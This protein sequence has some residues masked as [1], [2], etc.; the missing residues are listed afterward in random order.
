MGDFF[1]VFYTLMG[2]T[3]LCLTLTDYVDSITPRMTQICGYILLCMTCWPV[4]AVWVGYGGI[5]K[6]P[7][8]N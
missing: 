6:S 3:V 5:K 1:I 2:W 7:T 8:T 4:L